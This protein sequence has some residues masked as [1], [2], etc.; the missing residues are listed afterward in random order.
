MSPASVKLGLIALDQIAAWTVAYQQAKA[1]PN[2]TDA[3]VE[4]LVADTQ[5]QAEQ[6]SDAWRKA[7]QGA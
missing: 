7:R 1:N 4:R 3:E 2:M 6:I 5:A